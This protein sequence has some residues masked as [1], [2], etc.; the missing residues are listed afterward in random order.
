MQ[1]L[2]DIDMPRSGA[3]LCFAVIVLSAA[4]APAV[5]DWPHGRTSRL[6]S[7]DGRH[8][9]Y[10]E[11][12]QRGVREGPEL[13]LGHRGRS[14]RKRLLQLGGT[15]GA[16]WFPDSRNFVVIDRESSSSMNSYI[17][18]TEGRVTLDIGAALTRYDKDLGAV[19]RGH[20]YV[21]AQRL[22]NGHTLRVAVFGHTDEPPVRCFRF[23]YTVTRA[24][25]IGRLSRRISAAT[26]TGCDETSE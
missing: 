6:P 20:F 7:P 5:L 9:V 3:T 12:Y 10:G 23:I 17:H 24:G 4:T 11:S 8:I 18:D 13:W 26:A 22:R 21:E 16:F 15:A 14:E 19:A 25:E 1:T 2:Y